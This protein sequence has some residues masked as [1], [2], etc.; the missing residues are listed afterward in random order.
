MGEKK[1]TGGSEVSH[2]GH[3][4]RMKERFLKNGLESLNGHEVLELL[5]YYALPY[6]DTNDLGHRLEDD[7]GSLVNVLDAS[8]VDLQQVAGVTPHVATLLTLCGQL[9]HRYQ[10]ER[11]A[12]GQLLHNTAALGRFLV[13]Y[14]AGKKE[15]SVML[16]SMDN[17]GKLLNATRVFEGSVNSAQFN[18]R[19]A[20][21]QALRDN[22][23]VVA[24]AHNHP[25]GH[26]TFSDADKNTTRSFA[27]VLDLLE[28]RLIDHIV[29]SGTDYTSMAESGDAASVFSSDR[30]PPLKAVASV[31]D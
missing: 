4:Q 6:R 9:A 15:E 20:V 24:L 1:P 26:A 18:Y 12:V 13:P 31:K 27:Q 5:L 14:F 16:V 25:N 22:A 11:Y 28:I 10:K 17:R 29:V 19:V 30:L 7:F 21:Q 8:Y 23:T 2:G 3:R